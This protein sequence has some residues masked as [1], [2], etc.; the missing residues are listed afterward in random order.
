MDNLDYVH[1]NVTIAVT[2]PDPRR[3][4]SCFHDHYA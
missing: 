1:P 2:A 4:Q 3:V